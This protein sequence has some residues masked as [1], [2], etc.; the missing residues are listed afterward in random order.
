MCALTPGWL[1]CR[2]GRPAPCSTST[3]PYAGWVRAGTCTST[4]TLGVFWLFVGFGR[5]KLA[6]YKNLNAFS[7]ATFTN[8]AFY[9]ASKN[10]GSVPGDR[11]YAGLVDAFGRWMNP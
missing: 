4:A 1:G 5:G 10:P 6:F 9:Y 11:F 7:S 3:P 2:T 8:V